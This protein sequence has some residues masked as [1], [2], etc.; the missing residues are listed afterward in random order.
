MP[1][2]RPACAR[3]P[4][5]EMTCVP[6]W[7]KLTYTVLVVALAPVFAYEYGLRNFL[8]FSNVALLTTLLAIWLRSRLLISM[9]T[10]AVVVPEIG[11]NLAFWGRLLFGLPE[12][13]L[14]DYMFDPGIPLWARVMSLYHVP[15][16]FVLLWLVWRCGYDARALYWQ[17]VAAW[18]I[19]ALSLLLGTPRENINFVHGPL[20][21][22][23][24]PVVPPPGF[25][26]LL[27]VALPLLVYWP[28]H[29]VLR[30]YLAGNGARR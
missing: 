14:V 28:T 7:L 2:P 11:W 22:W 13:G 24:Q 21:A 20:D 4:P 27:M 18:V 10:V 17:T 3:R 16:P 6:S 29:A 25:L 26:L 23:S 12:F 30:A 8:W 5:R 9:M 15:L 1:G 19:L